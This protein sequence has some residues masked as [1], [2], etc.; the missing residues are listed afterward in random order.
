M[1]CD[2]NRFFSTFIF[3]LSLSCTNIIEGGS[4]QVG[5]RYM[6]SS[7][8]GRAQGRVKQC[9]SKVKKHLYLY[10]HLYCTFLYLDFYVCICIWC[11]A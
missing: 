4:E 6:E 2:R 11:S 7:Q 5:G 9:W 10:L 8:G 1:G 3:S